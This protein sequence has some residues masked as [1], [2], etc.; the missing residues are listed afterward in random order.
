L[1][2]NDA[3]IALKVLFMTEIGELLDRLRADQ[4]SRWQLG[5]SIYIET[6]LDECPQLR[7]DAQAVLDLI[8]NEIVLRRER[9]DDPTLE[10]YLHRFQD[11]EAL[12][13]QWFHTHPA[14]HDFLST[15]RV[16]CFAGVRRTEM[17]EDCYTLLLILAEA[18]SQQP[19]LAPDERC[20]AALQTLNRAG[21][22]G[23]DTRVYHL[24]R[25]SLL[26]QLGK[27]EEAQKEKEQANKQSPQSS[28]DH[29]LDGEEKYR[30]GAWATARTDF[31]RVLAIQPAR[32]LA[33][34][35]LALR[36][37]RLGEWEAARSGFNACL[38][39]RSD[40]VW[41]HLSGRVNA[42]VQEGERGVSTPRCKKQP[43]G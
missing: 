31:N 18:Q 11:L 6:Y 17:V 4:R 10:E 14:D 38:A 35:F 12:L 41:T 27:A 25:A 7:A 28:L 24:R 29:F 43:G 30:K 36:H 19:G 37:L 42:P 5:E 13:R 23:I 2:R 8:G 32:F 15:Q 26:E 9:G 20:R 1:A 21:R 40:F 3:S 39:R 33:Q 34:L 16:P 22:L